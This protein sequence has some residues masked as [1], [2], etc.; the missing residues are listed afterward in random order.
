MSDNPFPHQVLEGNNGIYEYA[1][2]NW[3]CEGKS[4]GTRSNVLIKDKIIHNY[5][6]KIMA[7][8]Y[9]LFLPTLRKEY[10]LWNF[11]EPLKFRFQYSTNIPNTQVYSSRDWHLDSGNKVI[12]G[13]WYFKEID[14]TAGGNLQITN[15]R[16]EPISEIKYDQNVMIIFPNTLNSWHRVKERK[17]SGI[18]RRFINML[19]EQE[20][21]LHSYRRDAKGIDTFK[22]VENYYS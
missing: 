22:D 21:K 6:E 13:L 20:T 18:K 16:G 12:I 17:V 2:N 19:V 7:D 8:S 4:P 9:S 14:D 15:G 10:P 1:L 11:D 3:I 5:C